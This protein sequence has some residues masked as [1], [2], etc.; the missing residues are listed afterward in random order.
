MTPVFEFVGGPW[1]GETKAL[2]AGQ[3]VRLVLGYPP[4]K[5]GVLTHRLSEPGPRIGVYRL[6]RRRDWLTYYKWMGE[7]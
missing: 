2:P 1:D 4:P 3:E 7:E 6:C 5:V